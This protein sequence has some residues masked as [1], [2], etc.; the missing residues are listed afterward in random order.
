[1]ADGDGTTLHEGAVLKTAAA[2]EA[3]VTA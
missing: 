1:M 2:T 3:E